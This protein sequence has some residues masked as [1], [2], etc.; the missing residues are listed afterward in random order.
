MC[1]MCTACVTDTNCDKLSCNTA[2]ML[3]VYNVHMVCIVLYFRILSPDCSLFK[4]LGKKIPL[5]VTVGMNGRIWLR[6]RS[7]NETICTMNAILAAEYTPDEKMKAMV[8]KIFGGVAAVWRIQVVSTAFTAR[9]WEIVQEEKKRGT[10]LV[11]HKW[12][13]DAG[14]LEG[15]WWIWY[16]TTWVWFIPGM[17][18]SEHRLL[19]NLTWCNLI[20]ENCKGLMAVWCDEMEGRNSFSFF[21][22]FFGTIEVDEPEWHQANYLH[23]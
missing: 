13:M 1:H 2:H 8:H 20:L 7:A 15:R 14:Q 11:L 5:E 17:V 22:F 9:S 23:T 6:C 3:C 19:T 21:F 10:W 4:V 16:N 18:Q 12:R